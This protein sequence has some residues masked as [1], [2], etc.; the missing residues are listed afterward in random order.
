MNLI[1]ILVLGIGAGLLADFLM[2]GSYGMRGDIGL[3]ILGA[4]LGWFIGSSLVQGDAIIASS[5]VAMFGA[6]ALIS[7][8]R[9]VTR[10]RFR[11]IW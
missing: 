11:R 7:V 2:K 5:V 1:A 4:L 3:G 9:V 10:D 8:S 6:L